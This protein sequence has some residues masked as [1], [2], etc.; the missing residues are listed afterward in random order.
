MDRIHR[1]RVEAFSAFMD[2]LSER[3]G[4]AVFVK[5]LEN[6]VSSFTT[7]LFHDALILVF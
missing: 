1:S 3:V 2:E 6:D 7:C 5:N 4:F